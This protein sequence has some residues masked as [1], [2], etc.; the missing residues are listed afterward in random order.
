MVFWNALI[1]YPSPA[2]PF[3]IPY[4][5]SSPTPPP[6]YP[7]TIQMEDVK[8]RDK[9]LICRSNESSLA[10]KVDSVCSPGTTGNGVSVFFQQLRRVWGSSCAVVVRPWQWNHGIRNSGIIMAVLNLFGFPACDEF[11]LLARAVFSLWWDSV[12]SSQQTARYRAW[13][14]QCEFLM[15]TN[16]WNWPPVYNQ[17]LWSGEKKKQNNNTSELDFGKCISRASCS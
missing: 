9:S 5:L 15:T 2:H 6:A 12:W 4:F 14:L 13:Y 10:Q 1:S 3:G 11:P 17:V 7:F 8:H 16:K